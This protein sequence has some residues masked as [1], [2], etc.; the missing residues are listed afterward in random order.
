MLFENNQGWTLTILSSL[1]C[2]TGTL[3]I[4]VENI[5]Q[6]L[7][8]RAITRRWPLKLER[9]Y[10]FM[11]NAM[12]FSSGGL[13]FTLLFR[14]LP[15][16]QLF[17]RA[18]WDD[19]HSESGAKPPPERRVELALI[20]A[21]FSGVVVY[22]GFSYLLHLLTSELVVHCSHGLD[23]ES[24]VHSHGG[25]HH[26]GHDHEHLH[27][28]DDSGEGCSL[29]P[30]DELEVEIPLESTPLRPKLLLRTNS[31]L[32]MVLTG[33]D[34][35]ECKGYSLAELCTFHTYTHDHLKLEPELHFCEVPELT[36]EP[37][38]DLCALTELHPTLTRALFHLKHDIHHHHVNTPVL[39]LLLIGI[40]TTLAITL[41]KFPEGFITYVTLQTD[42]TLGLLIFLSLL[43]HNLTEGFT[44]C[45]P[46]YYSFN[47]GPHPR[48]AKLKAALILAVLGGFSQPLGALAGLLFLRYN[49][50]R[51][52]YEGH[53]NWIFGLTLA[54]TAGFLTVVGLQLFGLTVSFGGLL[55]RAMVWCCVGMG[56]IGVSGIYVS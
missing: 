40:Q 19:G 29:D 17:L 54:V 53:L 50:N 26:G 9:N 39:R 35:L 13:L 34:A 32:H 28:H 42:P 33:H 16:A 49:S 47:A 24:H 52:G 2:V 36:D 38:P 3:L 56:M 43:A 10:L 51:S 15:E 21:Y 12:A 22:L 11:T 44:M 14:L 46:L 1:L 23:V 18:G 20:G 25:G 5:Y 55:N 31:I 41:H 4:Y 7:L 6:W 48:W 27:S 30:S 8:P 45:M 37:Q